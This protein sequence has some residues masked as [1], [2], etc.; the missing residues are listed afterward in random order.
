MH[1][2]AKGV[3]KMYGCRAA[4]KKKIEETFQKF[5]CQL[6][7]SKEIILGHSCVLRVRVTRLAIRA[8]A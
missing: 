5:G 6:L 7:L 1:F 2:L 8:D 3:A 4:E